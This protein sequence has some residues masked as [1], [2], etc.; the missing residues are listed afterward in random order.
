MDSTIS[1]FLKE[2]SRHPTTK[3]H[4][5]A[6]KTCS[7]FLLNQALSS[8]KESLQLSPQQMKDHEDW[9]AQEPPH[10]PP[11]SLAQDSFFAR[12]LIHTLKQIEKDI[13]GKPTLRARLGFFSDHSKHN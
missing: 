13:F 5:T 3:S 2:G 11:S 10:L 7:I 12:F 1:K 8:R 6:A 9:K 4:C